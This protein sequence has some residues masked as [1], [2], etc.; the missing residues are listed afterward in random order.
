MISVQSIIYHP[1]NEVISVLSVNYHLSI[2]VISVLKELIP[3]RQV[4]YL[5]FWLFITIPVI[6]VP[7]ANYHPYGVISVL[8]VNNHLTSGLISVLKGYQHPFDGVISPQGDLQHFLGGVTSFLSSYQHR[9]D[10]VVSR[11]I[12]SIPFVG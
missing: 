1:S 12:F 8:I 7:S 4:E 10:R 9:H 5:V 3:I 6:S 2:G 11:E